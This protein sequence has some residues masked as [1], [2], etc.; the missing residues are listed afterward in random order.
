MK[1]LFGNYIVP[2]F[3]TPQDH[4]KIE[5]MILKNLVI[6]IKLATYKIKTQ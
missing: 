4:Q 5:L 3:L 2:T 1:N 6:D